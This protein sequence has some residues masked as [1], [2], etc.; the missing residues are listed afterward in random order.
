MDSPLTPQIHLKLLENSYAFVLALDPEMNRVVGFINALSDGVQ[1][2][3]IPLLEVVPGYQRR[4]I[5]SELLK[6]ML[7]RLEAIP[8]IDLTCDPELQPFYARFGMQPSHG[9]VIRRY[10]KN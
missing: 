4:G 1:A 5:G 7:A 3:F 10:K 9:M 8:N 6:R 2:A